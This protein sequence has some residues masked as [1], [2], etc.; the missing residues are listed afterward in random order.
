[1]A[2]ASARWTVRPVSRLVSPEQGMKVMASS[3]EEVL[4]VETKRL[5]KGRQ[6]QRNIPPHLTT[7]HDLQDTLREWKRIIAAK[8]HRQAVEGRSFRRASSVARWTG[9]RPFRSSGVESPSSTASSSTSRPGVDSLVGGN[10]GIAD[11]LLRLAELP[12]NL[13]GDRGE[14]TE[15]GVLVLG[16]ERPDDLLL[17]TESTHRD[18]AGWSCG[19]SKRYP[20]DAVRDRPLEAS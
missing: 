18:E 16:A 8:V 3:V 5:P 17:S 4:E 10:R 2:R 15:S 13:S 20:L 1:M 19:T 7:V 14:T 11:G 6:P 12:V 9:P